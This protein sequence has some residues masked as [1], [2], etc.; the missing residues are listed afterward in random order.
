MT[1]TIGPIT[2]GGWL[3][4]RRKALDL[5]Q[6]EL[7]A[8]VGCSAETLRKI[9]AGVLRPSRQLAELLAGGLQVPD[10]EREAFMRF[11]RTPASQ[12]A[13]STAATPEEHG[14]PAAATPTNLQAQP[15]PFIGREREVEA[16]L[17][18]LA[19]PAVRLLTLVGPP[20]IG[21][22]RLA[23]QAAAQLLP[24]FRDGVFFVALS[25]I[26][27]HALVVPTIAQT[28]GVR[29]IGGQPLLAVLADHLRHKELLLVL[30]NFEQV[31]GAAPL[32]ADLLQAAPAVKVLVTS[33]TLL[34]LYGE[35]DFPVPPLDMPD[36]GESH[37][38]D[39]LTG[40][41]AV[42]LFTERA[43]AVK[44]DF[45][46]TGENA[47]AVAEICARLDG[48]PLAIELAAARVRVLP[49]QAIVHRLDH[50]L[51]L[52]TGGAR[53]LP[54][55]QQTLRN[56]IEASY[57]LLSSEEQTLFRRL[58]VF[59]GGCTL[60]A[61]EGVL[62]PAEDAR[63]SDPLDITESLVDKSLLRQGEVQGEARFWM[64]E[65]I[66][67]YAL[68]RLEESGEA[69]TLRKH[70]AAY[71]LAQAE[72]AEEEMLGTDQGLWLAKLEGDLDN[73]RAAIAYCLAEG[74]A[75]GAARIS[76]ALRRFWYLHAHMAEGRK[77]LEASLLCK[78]PLAAALRAKVLHGVGTLAW[79]Q[80][81]YEAA[82]ARYAESLDLFRALGDR[83]GEATILHNLGAVALA[84]GEWATARDLHMKS[85]LIFRE[86]GHDW[87]IA[88]SLANLG[89]VALNT[90]DY[91]EAK[92]QL[93]ESLALRRAL[94]DKQGIAQSLNNLGTVMRSKA[95]YNAAGLLHEE[96]RQVFKELGDS[97]SV[98][99]CLGNLGFVALN[100]NEHGEA[101]ALF[102]EGLRLASKLGAKQAIASCL[103]GLSATAAR[104]GSAERAATLLGAAEALREE[105]G[106]PLPPPER[107]DYEH[108]MLLV[109]ETLSAAQIEEVWAR[110]RQLDISQAT[111]YA[112]GEDER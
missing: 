73:I 41:E 49:P 17:A 98:A 74:D 11:A 104:E 101:Q 10:E 93:E 57:E 77:W 87:S 56:A 110:G 103:L 95:E 69:N 53:N 22:T 90:G 23:A 42:C 92:R 79:S 4:Q 67:E 99:L 38:L 2:F 112:L 20:G 96:S 24:L 60:E 47:R 46:V 91:E 102:E 105:I 64:L 85:L 45:R 5:T 75:P 78:G 72:E 59:V 27:D 66:R 35:H 70:H 58:A 16:V 71:F 8:R 39:R 25:P 107:V 19:R 108:V 9:E 109:R 3:K 30:D 100:S 37:T 88:Q 26:S 52:L 68:E 51:D 29:E 81:D 13:S 84:R 32:V 62:K 43:I 14:A 80:G 89:L 18:I 111:V 1:G 65:T 28:L 82:R 33:R 50:R 48:L 44:P 97:W 61:A 106:S 94:G 15:T 21:K 40:Y 36:P 12:A 34:H 63:A 86:L 54:A 55:R 7:S 76:G 83:H 31:E 6:G